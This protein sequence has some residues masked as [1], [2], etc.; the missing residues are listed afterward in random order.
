MKKQIAIG[1][2]VIAGGAALY[3]QNPVEFGK[4]AFQFAGVTIAAGNTF[5]SEALGGRIVAGKPFSATEE[6]HSI[7][8]LGDG[9]RIETSE[10]NRLYRDDQG[11]T[12]IEPASGNIRIF[13]PVAGFRAELNPITKAATMLAVARQARVVTKNGLNGEIS[14]TVT[15][16]T[17]IA[18][19]Q[20]ELAQMQSQYTANYPGVV[21][22]KKQ[23][24]D[25]QAAQATAPQAPGVEQLKNLLSNY[26]AEYAARTM[27]APTAEGVVKNQVGATVSEGRF[28]VTTVDGP[29]TLRVDSGDNGSVE[30]LAEQKVNGALAKGTRTTE[31]IPA[32]K[33]GNDRQINIVNERWFSDDLQLLVKSTSSDPRFGDTTYQLT[34]IVQASPDPSLFQIPADYTIKK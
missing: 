27:P 32:G 12:R 25:L 3:G 23:I 15:D 13:D 21:E 4:T 16:V 5:G 28:A 24:A 9:T 34:G 31:T 10:A 18:K 30:R 33:I 6:R 7:Q 17:R 1:I 8:I 19:L 14:A 2:A 11:R 29:V 26:Q 20:A 22:L